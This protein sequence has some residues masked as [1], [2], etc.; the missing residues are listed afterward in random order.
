MSSKGQISLDKLR[1]TYNL[2]DIKLVDI[3]EVNFANE[4]RLYYEI[5]FA[6]GM[7]LT[8]SVITSYNLYL[9]I[10]AIIFILFGIYNLVKYLLFSHKMNN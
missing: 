10:T 6:I 1:A 2:P 3:R 7:M 4:V 8:G 5:S 9:L